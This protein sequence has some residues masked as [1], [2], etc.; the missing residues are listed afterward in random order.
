MYNSDRDSALET[1]Y[2]NLTYKLY[3]YRSRSADYSFFSLFDFHFAPLLSFLISFRLVLYFCPHYPHNF[4]ADCHRSQ[5]KAT[6]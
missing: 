3:S 4:I 2:N 6:R 5:R 1:S